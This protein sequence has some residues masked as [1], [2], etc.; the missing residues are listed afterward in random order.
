MVIPCQVSTSTAAS[1]AHYSS[2]NEGF[3]SGISCIAS[4]F[5]MREGVFALRPWG[6]SGLLGH[7]VGERDRV[8]PQAEVRLWLG[9]RHDL[10]T[11]S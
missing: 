3:F 5:R 11:N 4:S 10:Q 1:F 6:L 7:W 8:F 9:F 2:L